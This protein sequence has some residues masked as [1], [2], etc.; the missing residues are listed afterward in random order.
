MKV[1]SKEQIKK[2][3]ERPKQQ[4]EKKTLL[5]KE[6]FGV[7]VSPDLIHQV[8]VSMSSNQRQGTAHTKDRSEVRGGGAKP[9]RQKGT[10]RARHGSRRSPI[11]IGGGATFGPRKERNYKKDIPTRMKRKAILG[12]LSAK[13]KNNKVFVIEDIKIKEPKTKVFKNQLEEIFIKAGL[14]GNKKGAPKSVLLVTPKNREDILRAA[15]NLAGVKIIEARNI[16]ALELTKHQNLL[17]L[18]D[19]VKVIKETFL[20]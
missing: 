9:W 3:L 15:K 7:K 6:V 10:G 14:P 12:I 4:A 19:S 20:N 2:G 5:P 11:W 17:L 18:K 16:N 8:V 1:N 13:A